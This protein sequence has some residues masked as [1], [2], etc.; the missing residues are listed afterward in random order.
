MR[1]F[2][3]RERNIEA[4]RADLIVLREK[5]KANINRPHGRGIADVLGE[6]GEEE[7]ARIHEDILQLCV[8]TMLVQGDSEKDAVLAIF[9]EEILDHIDY[10]GMVLMSETRKLEWMDDLVKKA[11][12]T[13][14]LG[15]RMHSYGR[16][17]QKVL[18]EK[19]TNLK[20]RI[21]EVLPNI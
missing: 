19:V 5:Y 18:D 6:E 21:L 20:K 10:H 2:E 4:F 11:I 7:R 15:A 14:S 8:D 12:N 13:A 3:S 1:N 9:R 16:Q 17:F